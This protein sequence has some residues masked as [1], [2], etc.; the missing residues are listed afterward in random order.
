MLKNN[1]F[2]LI[3]EV[4]VLIANNS[5]KEQTQSLWLKVRSVKRT[6]ELMFLVMIEL[7]M[8][9]AHLLNV[10]FLFK[11]FAIASTKVLSFLNT[12]PSPTTSLLPQLLQ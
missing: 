3:F 8:Q 9:Q 1:L 5:E 11:K 7:E 4:I 12:S 10:L 2:R 6:L